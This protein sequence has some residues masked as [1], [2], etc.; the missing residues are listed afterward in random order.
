M[1]IIDDLGG[2]AKGSL[3]GILSTIKNPFGHKDPVRFPEDFVA[4]F[5]CQEFIDGV[6]GEQFA[7]KGNMLPFVPFTFGGEQKIVKDYYPGN[8][9]PVVQPLGAREA[10]TT[11]K[12]RLKLKEVDNPSGDQVAKN[13]SLY[14]AAEAMQRQIDAF[15]IRGNLCRFTLG[16]W[17]RWGYIEKTEFD[18]IQVSRIEYAVTLAIVG[19]TQPVNAKF[20]NYTKAVPFG[21]NKEL[22]A[23]LGALVPAPTTMPKD[24]AKLINGYTNDMATAI[25]AVTNFV[26][27]TLK[28]V[29]DLEGSLNRAIGLIKNARAS[30][31]VFKRRIRGIYMGGYNL[32]LEAGQASLGLVTD[33]IKVAQVN[34]KVLRNGSYLFTS[35]SS[36]NQI[37]Q[38]LARMQ[39]QFSL[40]IKTKPRARYVTKVGDTLQ[41]IA[42]KFYN[43]ANQWKLIYDH[44]K[45]TTT[46]LTSGTLIEIPKQ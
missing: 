23:A 18:M 14:A 35:V 24:L 15:R 41:K 16:M 34:A 40:L 3:D 36:T 27:T 13:G 17:V 30:I 38:I 32:G 12:G 22:L 2:A 39:A 37:E 11:I 21:V 31:S 20:V 43:D 44:N 19:F 5:V 9:E 45:M 46:V 29:E 4:G 10:S 33:S 7:L 6:P 28:T 26:G 25:G 1:S 42:I 8:P